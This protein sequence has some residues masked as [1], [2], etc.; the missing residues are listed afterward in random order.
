MPLRCRLSAT[1]FTHIKFFDATQAEEFASP[2]ASNFKFHP[3]HLYGSH[4]SV[5]R[6]HLHL[7]RNDD[8]VAAAMAV[9]GSPPRPRTQSMSLFTS[10]RSCH[11][12]C[13]WQ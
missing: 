13:V 2:G 12:V 1:C 11:P 6:M 9:S 8:G 5:D 3:Y 4:S 7:E 10:R